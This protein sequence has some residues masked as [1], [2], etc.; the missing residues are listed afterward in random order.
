MPAAFSALKWECQQETGCSVLLIKE[1]L[2]RQV[3]NRIKTAAKS[4]DRESSTGWN[5]GC[6]WG[7]LGAHKPQC[8]L[9]DEL[10]SIYQNSSCGKMNNGS[11]AGSA[12]VSLI[13][14]FFWSCNNFGGDGEDRNKR[15]VLLGKA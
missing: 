1:V 6:G 3:L 13:K 8:A 14:H 4:L 11:S 10:S 5:I 7:M 9:R 2:G 15:G 12:P